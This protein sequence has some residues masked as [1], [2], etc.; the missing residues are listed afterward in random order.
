MHYESVDT[1]Y[2][3]KQN[4]YVFLLMKLKNLIEAGGDGLKL[5]LIADLSF[6]SKQALEALSCTYGYSANIVHL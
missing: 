4:R 5:Q 1:I 2:H 3:Q 6:H